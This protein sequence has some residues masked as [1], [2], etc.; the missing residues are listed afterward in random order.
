MESYD[1][2]VDYVVTDKEVFG[3]KE[4]L[5]CEFG[6]NMEYILPVTAG[7]LGI[8][9]RSVF[10]FLIFWRKRKIAKEENQVIGR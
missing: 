6:V 10:I 7:V 2:F 3:P 5:V 4:K 1:V 8:L 9:L